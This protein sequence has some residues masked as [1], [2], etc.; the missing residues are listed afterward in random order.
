MAQVITSVIHLTKCHQHQP[1]LT[2][3]HKCVHKHR[4]K[5]VCV[6]ILTIKIHIQI[7]CWL[8]KRILLVIAW[9][10]LTCIFW[11]CE[12][13]LLVILV[14]W[15]NLP[16]DFGCV[17][18]SYLLFWLCE[19]ILLVIV[20]MNLTCDCVNESYLWFW[21]CEWI[22]LVILVVW[23]NL[24]CDCVNESYMFFLDVWMNL[25]CVF[26]MCEWILLVFIWLYEQIL[27]VLFGCANNFYFWWSIYDTFII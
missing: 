27:L 17:N 13:I 1:N 4:E 10:N 14:V 5:S 20:W 16:F 19:W 23:T 21:L 6:C 12:W 9:T 7:N 25:K 2:K 22:L 3:N 11:L 24:T 18:E 15:T 8:C 26:L